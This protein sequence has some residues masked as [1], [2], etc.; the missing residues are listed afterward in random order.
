MTPRKV[1][2]QARREEI[3]AAA[4]RVFARRGFAAS[5]IDDVASAAGVAKGS[6]Y[7]YFDSREELLHAAF[8]ALSARSAALL[9]GAAEERGSAR[10]RLEALVRSVLGMLTAEPEVAH[11]MLDLWA[12]GRGRR[13]SPIDL[14]HTYRTYRGAITALLEQAGDE[15]DAAPAS[16]QAHAAIIVGAIEG[17]VLQW[18][19]DPEVDPVGL[20][21]PLVRMLVPGRPA[22]HVTDVAAD[23]P[24]NSTGAGHG[25][26]EEAP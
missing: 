2:R 22:A 26:G 6:V 15:G 9:R 14:A 18:L 7:L 16:P 3:L 8:D 4:V 20:A 13:D 23:R 12:S 11:I 19:M 10:D 1:D 17:C 25:S 5:R 24:M 21:D